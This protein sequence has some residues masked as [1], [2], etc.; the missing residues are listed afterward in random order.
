MT[1]WS[2]SHL[3]CSS[4]HRAGQGRRAIFYNSSSGLSDGAPV[5]EEVSTDAAVDHP[6]DFSSA[7]SPIDQHR[8]VLC[9]HVGGV[10]CHIFIVTF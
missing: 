10:M 4:D 1:L 9:G 5:G 3:I 8:Y 6:L 2:A 7:L